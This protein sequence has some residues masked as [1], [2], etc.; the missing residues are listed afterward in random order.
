M[1]RP[2]GH[3][4]YI[5]DDIDIL[6]IAKVAL[7]T[8]GGLEVALIHGPQMAL[9]QLVRAAPDLIL[10]D[11]MMPEIDGLMLLQE[12]LRHPLLAKTPVIFMTAKVQPRELNHY[13][14][15]GAIGVIP[16]PFDPMSLADEVRQLWD[17]WNNKE[18]ISALAP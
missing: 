10:L 9:E 17:K 1:P 18:A 3:V 8:V 4:A 13:L 2:L 15:L 7:N 5:D 12:I 14:A 16:K 11:V 6:C